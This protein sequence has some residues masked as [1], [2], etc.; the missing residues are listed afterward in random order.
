MRTFV[1]VPVNDAVRGKLSGMLTLLS[2]A[3][4]RVRWVRPE[5]LHI[6]L[7]FL[8]DVPPQDLDELFSALTDAITETAP[9]TLEVAGL[10][11]FPRVSAPRVAWAGIGEGAEELSALAGKTE[12]ACA[13]LGYEPEARPYRPHL[14]LGRA[15]I[16]S[17]MADAAALLTKCA[18]DSFGVI[19]VDEAVVYM[20]EL[21][22]SGPVYSPMARIPLG[23]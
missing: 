12:T 11:A 23:G 5:N 18:K 7:K 20:S 4:P 19:D 2:A 21:R 16:P 17:D 15:R 6:T 9:F 8:G 1:A 10:G 13:A 22:K 14:T 3:A